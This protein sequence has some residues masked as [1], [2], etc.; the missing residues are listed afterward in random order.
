MQ[1]KFMYRTEDWDYIF[2][3]S[4]EYVGCVF[5]PPHRVQK[6]IKLLGQYLV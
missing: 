6:F 3:F 4:G 5:V 2:K 1:I